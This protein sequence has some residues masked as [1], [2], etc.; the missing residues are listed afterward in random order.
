MS[1]PIKL[2]SG[3][4]YLSIFVLSCFYLHTFVAFINK[5]IV[6]VIV[7]YPKQFPACVGTSWRLGL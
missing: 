7:I 1:L 6:I 2:T 5:I 3:I 4:L